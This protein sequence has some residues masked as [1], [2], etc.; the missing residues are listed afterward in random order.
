MKKVLTLGA[1]RVSKPLVDHFIDTCGYQVTLADMD[2][3]RAE[4]I[5]AGRSLGT[6]VRWKD[7]EETLLD[8]L[9]GE[10][11][12]AVAIVPTIIHDRSRPAQQGG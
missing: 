5:V 10:C 8:R 2:V 12:I 4:T 3:S 1:G 11:D 7:D 9:V 6:A